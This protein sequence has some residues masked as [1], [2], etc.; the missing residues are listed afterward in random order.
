LIE[1][2]CVA[3]DS[4]LGEEVLITSSLLCFLADSPM[5]AEITSTVMPGNS[6]NPCRMCD[7]GVSSV[8]MK[9]TMAY[10]QFFLQISADGHWVGAIHPHVSPN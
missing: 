7:L 3:Y 5:H 8:A 4:G 6:R 2:G 1:E 9:K 10:L